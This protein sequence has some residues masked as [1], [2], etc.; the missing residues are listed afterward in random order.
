MRRL[1]Q[2]LIVGAGPTG[3]VLAPCVERAGSS[4][5][6]VVPSAAGRLYRA[7]RTRASSASLAAYLDSNAI[8][9]R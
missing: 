2:V 9:L 3:L 8:R 6:R 7:G 4:A 1:A 5:R